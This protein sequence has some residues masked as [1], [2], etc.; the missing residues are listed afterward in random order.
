MKLKQK[1]VSYQTQTKEDEWMGKKNKIKRNKITPNVEILASCKYL[2]SQSNSRRHLKWNYCARIRT[3]T[4]CPSLAKVVS[5][6][7]CPLPNFSKGFECTALFFPSI[8]LST[9]LLYFPLQWQFVS[10]PTQQPR[11]N[12]QASLRNS[13]A[14]Y[15]DECAGKWTLCSTLPN[16]IR[17]KST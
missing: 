14:D 9:V 2:P 1:E 16:N 15:R 12:W 7:Q 5:Q 3:R 13:K 17:S 4:K 11:D 8:S 6:F 10:Q